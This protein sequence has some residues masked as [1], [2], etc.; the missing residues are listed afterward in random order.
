MEKE[1]ELSSGT[2]MQD[3]CVILAYIQLFLDDV[4]H[5]QSIL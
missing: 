1:E 5:F 4:L 2:S 3:S